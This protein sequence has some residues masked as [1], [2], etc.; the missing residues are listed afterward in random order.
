[1]GLSDER[2]IPIVNGWNLIPS[3]STGQ[4]QSTVQPHWLHHQPRSSLD[5]W[6]ILSSSLY[7]PSYTTTPSR[8][9][10]A[11][12]K[13]RPSAAIY[14][15]HSFRITPSSPTRSPTAQLFRRRS[16][17]KSYNHARNL[18][19]PQSERPFHLLRRWRLQTQ[20]SVCLASRAHPS[21]VVLLSHRSNN[22]LGQ[23]H[24]LPRLL[25]PRLPLLPLPTPPRSA[26][27]VPSHLFFALLHSRARVPEQS[28]TRECRANGPNRADRMGLGR[29]E[30]R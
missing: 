1:M 2:E 20:L 9:V 27:P 24:P 13:T 5:S 17:R 15:V 25:L 28:R 7:D 14:T 23:R 4:L 8:Q 19:R 11:Q 6:F 21:V 10:E 29:P 30:Q 22:V 26:H 18:S 12:S 3:T 16:R